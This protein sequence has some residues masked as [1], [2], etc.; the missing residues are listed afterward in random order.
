MNED[1]MPAD[2]LIPPVMDS[3]KI[4]LLN[5]IL[6]LTVPEMVWIRDRDAVTVSFAEYDGKMLVVNDARD[7][8]NTELEECSVE[9]A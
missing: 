6:E 4:L 1:V 2:L 7:D 3:G 8:S 5:A 9:L